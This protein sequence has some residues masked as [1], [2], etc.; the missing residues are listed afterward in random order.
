[1]NHAFEACEEMRSSSFCPKP[2]RLAVLNAGDNDPI[3]PLRW[4]VSHHSERCESKAGT[5][6]PDI[7]HP[8]LI[9][10]DGSEV[11]RPIVITL[12]GPNYIP[13][14]QAMSSFLKGMKLWRYVTGDIE[15]PVQGV[16]ETSTEYIERLEEWDSKNHQIITWIR[17]TSI[18]SISL[19][20]GRFD[21]AHDIWDF[22][23]TKYTNADLACQYQLLTSL[24]QQRQEPGQSISVY[25]SQ[26]YFIWDQLTL[27]EPKW[28]SAV[29]AA[30]F[31]TYRD[32]QHMILFLMGLSDVYEP[33]RASLLHRIPSPTLEQAIS[34]LLSEE[35]RLG[36]ISTSHVDTALAVPSFRT[37][38]SSSGS[39]GSSTSSAQSFGSVSRH[40]ECTFCHAID[41]RLLTCHVRVCKHCRQRG[42]GHYLSDCP[43]VPTHGDTRPQS[44]AGTAQASSTTSA[45]ST[46]IDVSDLP[47]IVQ[48]I[49]SA[50]S[51]PS[52]TLF[53]RSGWL[54]CRAMLCT[55]LLAPIF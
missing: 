55:R 25:L 33:L 46:L 54:W 45:S 14:S 52:T 36:L 49:L 16:A 11:F 9:I 20:F 43:K 27:S 51:N 19:Q 40:N 47:A 21:T 30:L 28:V 17:N 12:E 42:P 8:E 5:D 6:L 34:E 26:I 38:G 3:W 53:A 37:C 18:P 13:W 10:M 50:S 23:A 7:I 29:D 2:H 41:H 15:S 22:L 48:Q 44:T 1:M 39:R 35:T 32:R 31:A 4:H 24:C